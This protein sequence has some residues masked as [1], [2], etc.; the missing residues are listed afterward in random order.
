MLEYIW[1]GSPRSVA[2]IC[3][4]IF[5]DPGVETKHVAW[6][7]NEV[8]SACYL[9]TQTATAPIHVFGGM[10][11]LLGTELSEVIDATRPTDGASIGEHQSS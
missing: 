1:V 6:S 11:S 9:I 4:R 2:R 10:Q 8:M 5:R 7:C 3:I